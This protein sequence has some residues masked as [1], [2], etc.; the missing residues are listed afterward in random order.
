MHLVTVIQGN[1]FFFLFSFLF[2]FETKPQEA[3]S[4]VR[5][6]WQDLLAQSGSFAGIKLAYAC[7]DSMSAPH[8]QDPSEGGS[9]CAALVSHKVPVMEGLLK[10]TQCLRNHLVRLCTQS[11]ST[12]AVPGRWHDCVTHATCFFVLFFCFAS[13]VA[14]PHSGSPR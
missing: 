3:D 13:P 5:N 8:L 10:K 7:Y 12:E 1:F 2:Q 14:L 11:V 6:H 4:T 9:R